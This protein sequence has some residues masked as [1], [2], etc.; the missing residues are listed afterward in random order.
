MAADGGRPYLAAGVALAAA[1]ILIQGSV[2]SR[3]SAAAQAHTPAAFLSAVVVP[4]QLPAGGS[5]G[6]AIYVEL[7]SAVGTASSLPAALPVDLSAN[8]GGQLGLPPVVTIPAGQ[9]AVRIP[10]HSPRAPGSIPV[11]LQ[12]PGLP[13]VR[14]A[15]SAVKAS[16]PGSGAQLQLTLSPAA[17][18]TGSQGSAWTT[19]VLED[20]EG[21]PT[22]TP[23]PLTVALVSSA[24]GALGVPATLTIPAGAFSAT[25]PVRIGNPGGVSV[26]ALASGF[27]SSTA[28]ATV[29]GHG[30]APALLRVTAMPGAILPGGKVRLVVQAID[31][32]NVP[33]PFP[34]GSLEMASSDPGVLAVPSTAVPTCTN[35]QQAVVIVAQPGGAPGGTDITVAASGV[36]SADVRITASGAAPAALGMT[37]APPAVMFGQTHA[38][39]LVLQPLAASG[40]PIEAV[41]AI[42]V[43]LSGPRG[44]APVTAV[45]PAGAVA[46]AVRLGRLT[47]GSAA[48]V[49]A[50]APGLRAASVDL[51][52]LAGR[53]AQ[54][55]PTGVALRVGALRIPVGWLL[56]AVLLVMALLV[57]ALL[58]GEG[59]HARRPPP[60]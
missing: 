30:G 45:I 21:A 53:G 41:R 46:V 52:A 32:R 55:Q 40:Q 54:T 44:L 19:V 59:R 48:I 16:G 60:A 22:V 47:A 24:P 12:S 28:K 3:A 18:F 10:I 8:D 27:R 7:V 6:A 13:A 34:C 57:F 25:A 37:V 56:A 33:V 26:T 4:S 20:A 38:G 29:F 14:V 43:T 51:S 58:R 23:A 42:T 15:V 1:L 39:W 5:G 17:F 35:G 2:Q 11:D 50:T 31:A 49:S 36:A 9:S